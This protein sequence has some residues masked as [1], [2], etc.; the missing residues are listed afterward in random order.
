MA[1]SDFLADLGKPNPF[2]LTYPLAALGDEDVEAAG[3]VLAA[4]V[5][6]GDVRAAMSLAALGAGEHVGVVEQLLHRADP[7]DQAFLRQAVALLG[8]PEAVESGLLQDLR[9]SNPGVRVGAAVA[10]VR[11]G[12]LFVPGLLQA[13]TDASADVRTDA[14]DAL[15]EIF[16]LTALTREPN[17]S[18]DPRSPLRVAWLRLLHPNASVWAPQA[19]ALQHRFERLLAGA[20][21]AAEGLEPVP[22]TP[23]YPALVAA[24]V[25][26]GRP[27][28]DGL[29]PQTP[30]DRAWVA[31][32]LLR[33]CAWDTLDSRAVAPLLN[34][35]VADVDL[36]L[37]EIVD[38]LGPDHP[39]ALA[40][41]SALAQRWSD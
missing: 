6:R 4:M 15:I 36:A 3:Q 18:V 20:T 7:E 35:H 33:R 13:L 24:W 29:A 28:D 31:A 21:P 8:R 9:S 32:L 2:E 5:A 25:E 30:A 16:G 23:G 34:L 12:R 1:F 14:L 38:G 10:M 41:A 27:W 26:G 40:T 22:G 11:G 19:A 17:G 37:D 39:F